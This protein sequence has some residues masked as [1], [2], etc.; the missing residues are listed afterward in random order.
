VSL[1][2]VIKGRDMG[3][4]PVRDGMTQTQDPLIS[5]HPQYD[6]FVI[7]GAGCY[8]RAKDLP[9][10]GENIVKVIKGEPINPYYGWNPDTKPLHHD[11]PLLLSRGN[12][13][14]LEREAE[15]SP[16]VKNWMSRQKSQTKIGYLDEI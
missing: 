9:S 10:L 2:Y 11:Q 6:N 1:P 4:I 14:D 16:A 13:M 5:Q 8:N 12:F 15:R 3:L 7:A